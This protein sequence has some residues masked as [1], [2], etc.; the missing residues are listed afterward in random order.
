LLCVIN[1]F[2]TGKVLKKHFHHTNFVSFGVTRAVIYSC[3]CRGDWLHR[4][5]D[6][7]ALMSTLNSYLSGGINEIGK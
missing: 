7:K 6:R 1:H 3:Y 4:L 5:A 2:V